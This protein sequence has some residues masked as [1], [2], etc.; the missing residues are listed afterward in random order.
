MG[1]TRAGASAKH[2]PRG[3]VN[4]GMAAGR[5][6]PLSQISNTNI[7]FTELNHMQLI[8]PKLA[9]PTAMVKHIKYVHIE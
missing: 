4:P 3:I 8:L 9:R 7:L 1:P 6:G 5:E 2:K